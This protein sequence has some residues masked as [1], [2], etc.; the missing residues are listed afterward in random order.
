LQ[1][2][3]EAILLFLLL[4]KIR[5]RSFKISF[6][7]A[8]HLE[9]DGSIEEVPVGVVQLWAGLEDSTATRTTNEENS[10]LVIA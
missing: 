6:G 2:R 9:E 8:E 3:E 5:P 10:I 4:L 1:N 7:V